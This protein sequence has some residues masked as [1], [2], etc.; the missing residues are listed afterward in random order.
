MSDPYGLG[1]MDQSIRE[2]ID[3]GAAAERL[4]ARR[5]GT[6]QRR[7]SGPQRPS[8]RFAAAAS[9]VRRSARKPA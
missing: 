5:A 6:E 4:G 2:R 8:K 9:R 3:R 1:C 7:I